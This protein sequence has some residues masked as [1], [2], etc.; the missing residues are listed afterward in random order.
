MAETM[1]RW[2]MN[3]LGRE[4][5]KLTQEP[6]PKP[7]PGEVRVRVNAVALNYRDKMVIEGMMPIPLSFPFTPASD[8][9][10]VVDSIGEGVTRFQP[11]AR[12]ISTF[13]P[14]W[15]DGRPQ[16]DARHLPY[17]T[18]G[19]YFP[20]MLAEY[21]IVNENGLVA[22]PETLDDVEAS[23]LPCA[24]LTAWFALV[25]RGNLRAGQSV[26]VQGTGGVAIFALQIAKA[27]G[28]EVYVTSGS[29]EKLT[30]AKK[31]GADRGINRLKGDWAEALLT[32]T[33][34][35]GID[36]I[37]ETVGGEN[38]Q[39]SLRAVAVHGRISVIGVL[40]GSEI[41][42]SAGELLLKSPVIQ[43]IGVG[44]RRALEEF[45]RAVEVTGLKPVIEQ[46]YRFD[47]LEQALEHLDRG[48]FGKIVL[49]RE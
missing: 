44:H 34:D 29:D 23:T 38:L 6:V 3:A 11:G 33:Q 47:Q 15:I 1:Q 12:V 8:M 35:R 5:L 18:S 32:L 24:G 25:E 13:F 17:K 43:G 19:G 2:S 48:A 31:L 46:R 41:T 42:L 9:A 37:I 36:H 20:G 39:H 40:A 14:E 21:V 22:T 26:L 7:G 10:G 49:T 30:R 27:L 45:V 4:N 16:A 28:A